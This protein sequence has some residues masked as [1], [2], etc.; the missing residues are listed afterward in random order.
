MRDALTFKGGIHPLKDIHYGKSLSENSEI[1]QL[2]AGAVVKIPLSQHIGA[3]SVPL[4]KAGD[5]VLMGQKIAEAGGFVSVPAHASVS[6]KVLGIE[7][8]PTVFG[9]PVDAIVIENDGQYKKAFADPVD[10]EKLEPK[11]IIDL[12]KDA[13]IVG[14]GG[15]AFPQHVKLMPPPE[16]KI[17]L[18]LINA[19]EC[20]PF[21][22][23]DYRLMLESPERIVYGTK[24]VMRALGVQKAIIG[25][26]DNKPAAIEA[27]QKAV[28][29]HGI[30][31]AVLKSKYPQGSEK[32]MID[33]ITGRVVPSGGLPMD[34]GVVV[35]NVGS[36]K[37]LADRLLDGEPLIRRV[38]TVTG[39]VGHPSNFSAPVGMSIQELIDAAGGFDGEPMKIMMGGPMMGN[40]IP[41]LSC[42]VVKGT[43]GI[44]VLDERYLAKK[45]RETECIYCGK[46]AQACPIYLMPMQLLAYSKLGDFDTCAELGALD[47]ISCG[48]CT[49]VCPAKKHIAQYIKLAKDEIAAKKAA[50]K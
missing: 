42:A 38:V 2:P 44:V 34:V 47:C 49:Y 22:T 20:E 37:A 8:I 33:A 23:A 6:G 39:A 40:S 50:K 26:E 25:I 36:V 16:K 18:L 4:V 24:A 12:I 35:S 3:P 48:S 43:S 13:G 19:A 17:N 41:D 15:A 28:D 9:R 10:Y 27:M 46:C 11:E 5:E 14:M 30:R 21:L 45:E 1:T 29:T 7:Q 32:Q 31:V